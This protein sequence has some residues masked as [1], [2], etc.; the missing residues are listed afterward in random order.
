MD[1]EINEAVESAYRIEREY[2]FLCDRQLRTSATFTAAR[3]VAETQNASVLDGCP[4][5]LIEELRHWVRDFQQGGEFGFVSN[6]GEVD[7]SA[8]MAAVSHVVGIHDRPLSA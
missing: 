3:R 4:D 5:W 1:A 8:L 7:H 6:L 2:G